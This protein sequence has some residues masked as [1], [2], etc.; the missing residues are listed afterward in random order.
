VG[1]VVLKTVEGHLTGGYGG[2]DSHPLPPTYALS[3]FH[4]GEQGWIRSKTRDIAQL[5][6]VRCNWKAEVFRPW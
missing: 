6:Q 4:I 1:S 5:E 2:F 3:V